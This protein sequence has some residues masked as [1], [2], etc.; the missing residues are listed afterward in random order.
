VSGTASLV[1]DDSCAVA[2][3]VLDEQWPDGVVTRV[4]ALPSTR[5]QLVPVGRPHDDLSARAPRRTAG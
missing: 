4:L 2:E 5:V 1:E 3:A